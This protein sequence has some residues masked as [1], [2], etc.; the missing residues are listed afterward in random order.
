MLFFGILFYF[1]FHKSTVDR[2]EL[3]R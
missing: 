3:L 1:I 2:G